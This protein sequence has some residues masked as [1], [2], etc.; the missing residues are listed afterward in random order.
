MTPGRYSEDQL[1]ERPAIRLFEEL[2]W[3][4]IDAYRETLGPK[5]LLGRDNRSEVFL[6]GRLRGA[7]SG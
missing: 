1:V 4:H 7:L 5:G 2:G 6:T 3:E